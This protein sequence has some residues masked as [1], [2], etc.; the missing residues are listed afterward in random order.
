MVRNLALAVAVLLAMAPSLLAAEPEPVPADMVVPSEVPADASAPMLEPVVERD[1]GPRIWIGAEY[2]YWFERRAPSPPLV[3]TGPAASGGVLNTPGTV[4]AYGD[5]GLDFHDHSG[6]RF[7]LGGWLTADRRIGVEL[8]ALILETHTIHFPMDSTKAGAPLIARPFFNV[9]SGAEDA[10]VITSPGKYLGGID[11]FADSRFW[12]A[13]ANG[14]TMLLQGARGNIVGLAGFRYVGL[15]ESFRIS[16]SST[17]LAPGPGFLGVPVPPPDIVSITDRFE[18]RNQF[19]GA[20]VGTRAQVFAGRFIGDLVG[21]IGLGST[22]Q[23]VTIGGGTSQT[24]PDG[25]IHPAPGGLFALPS[26]IGYYNRDRF[27][28]M[29][30]AGVGLGYRVRPHIVLRAGYTFL[31]WSNVARASDQV[32]RDINPRQVPSALPF[33]PPVTPL[34]PQMPF[35]QTGFWAQGIDAG[36][37]FQF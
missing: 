6:G 2:L 29:T 28:F 1:S 7:T 27:G 15:D 19:Y 16:Q 13:E 4:V 10:Q 30:E 26:N 36:L 12:G 23:Q 3:T 25:V 17:L 24:G 31:F 5:S 20:Q 14:L 11:V 18:T 22:H 8:S 34:Q 37:T 9:V 33:G 21:K 35:N 32:N